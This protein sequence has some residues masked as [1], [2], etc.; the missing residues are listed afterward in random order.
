MKAGAVVVLNG[1]SSS[2]KTTVARALGRSGERPWLHLGVDALVD[3]LDRR[4][5]DDAVRV[6]EDGE[7]VVGP[8]ARTLGAAL[9]AAV[10]ASARS[11]VDVVADDLF[12]E[13]EWYDGWRRDLSGLRALVVGVVAPL[14]VVEERERGRGDRLRGAARAQLPL[15]HSWGDYDLVLDTATAG[16]EACAQAILTALASLETRLTIVREAGERGDRA[17]ELLERSP[18]LRDDPWVALSL[19][20]PSRIRDAVQ[21]GGP[22]DVPPLFYVARSRLAADTVPAA[23]DLLARGADPNGAAGEQWTNLSITCS[24]GDARLA[25]LLLDAGAEPN[26][27]DSLYHSIEPADGTCTRLLL[28]RGARVTGTSALHHALDYERLGRVRLLLERGGDPNEHPE[29]PALHHAVAR[30]RSPELLRLLVEHGA[31]V[32][33]R[34]RDGRTAY[35]HAVRRGRDDLA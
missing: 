20:D 8:V 26:D 33:A 10:V 3:G 7:L 1:V 32:N 2:G 35:R 30:G 12:L 29:W 13:R 18:E 24:R 27:D 14:E 19:G 23:R 17:R 22:L 31:D 28:D 4:W 34:D 21:P 5:V 16:P 25:E 9:R 11:G 15:V 6:G